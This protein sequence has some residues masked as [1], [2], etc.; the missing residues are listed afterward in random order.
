MVGCRRGKPWRVGLSNLLT[1]GYNSGDGSRKAGERKH[2]VLQVAGGG[3][4]RQQD[5]APGHR[6]WWFLQAGLIMQKEQNPSFP[7]LPRNHFPTSLHPTAW[8][9]L[10]LPGNLTSPLS[11]C[12]KLISAALPFLPTGPHWV[13]AACVFGSPLPP[14]LRTQHQMSL[15]LFGSAK[16]SLRLELAETSA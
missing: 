14:G 4:Q 8:S 16:R 7:E 9:C 12:T 13:W 6:G 10:G 1:P 15:G 5:S 3:G 11:Y 2:A